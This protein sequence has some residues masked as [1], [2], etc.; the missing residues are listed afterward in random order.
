MQAES[1]T[2]TPTI[3]LW[4][5]FRRFKKKISLTF[6]LVVAESILDLLFP[7]FI[8]FAIN[9]LL[10]QSYTGVIALALLGFF[11]LIVGSGRRFYDTR[12]YASIY[13]T[14]S[15]EMVTR[16]QKK[17]NS[18]STISAR[19]SLLTEFVEFLENSMPM[20]VTSLFGLVGILAI[21]FSLNLAV[22][23]ASTALLGLMILVYLLSGKWNFRYNKNYND[24]LE[25]QVDALSTQDMDV[26]SSHFKTVMR[27][28]IKL[29]DLETVNYTVIWLGIIGL[30]VYAPIAVI[31]SGLANYGLVFSI[32][33]YVFQYIESVVTLPYFIQQIIRLQEISGRLNK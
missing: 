3:T 8:G 11:A 13:T 4:G 25:N 21:L 12:A 29:S 31:D 28:N 6:F 17:E 18:I 26:I 2:I 14:L 16:E 19:A 22:F 1:I 32:L 30:L 27:W 9:S 5:L 15:T 24:T 23:A 33:M 20:I 7:L 10:E